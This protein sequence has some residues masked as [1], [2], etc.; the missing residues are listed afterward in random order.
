MTQANLSVDTLTEFLALGN[1]HYYIF[2]LGRLVHQI[3]NEQFA[4]IEAGQQPYPTP[5]QRHAHL[6]IVFWHKSNS[7]Q[8]YIWFTKLPL[9]ERGLINHAARQHYLQII[10]QALGRDITAE[11]KPEQDELLKQNPYIFTPDDDKRAAFYA[12]VNILLAQ[13]PSIYFEDVEHFILQHNAA[14]N[15][16]NLG[17]QGLHEV[18]ARLS[19]QLR[20]CDAIN[21]NLTSWPAPFQHSLLVAL[22]HHPLPD[23]LQ[24]RIFQQLQV[25]IDNSDVPN[26]ITLLR[27]L[28]S[29]IQ[30]A[31]TAPLI[32]HLHSILKQSLNK[33]QQED[34]L[35]TVAARLWPVLLNSELRS[36]YLTRLSEDPQLFA[37]VFMD[38]V[39][40]PELR[41]FM[42]QILRKTPATESS[43]SEIMNKAI[44]YLK[45]SLHTANK[46]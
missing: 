33:A 8:P 26:Q 10:M 46:G 32:N 17:L 4:A 14:D 40:L 41:P 44:S 19:R 21:Q 29:S 13:P 3:P 27:A 12:K 35:V 37:Q 2:D 20:L 31:G 39:G 23:I 18:A 1:T 7:K 15:W 42:L 30:K 16:Q 45:S 9:D 28:A 11:S 36:Q 25:A 6:A 24:K 34:L 22:E 43:Q 38:L 5:S